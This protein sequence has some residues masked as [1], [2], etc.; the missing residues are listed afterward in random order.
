M[1]VTLRCGY[2][3]TGSSIS[4][5]ALRSRSS[6]KTGRNL[7]L[8]TIKERGRII[9]TSDVQ[10]DPYEARD[11]SSPPSAKPAANEQVG[12][13]RPPCLTEA[14]SLELINA[15]AHP[16]E[17]RRGDTNE[18]TPRTAREVL[19]TAF[20]V[21]PHQMLPAYMVDVSPSPSRWISLEPPASSRN[22]SVTADATGP[23]ECASHNGSYHEAVVRQET[24]WHQSPRERPP[25]VFPGRC[26]TPPP[27][28]LTRR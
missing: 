3:N 15:P 9:V 10:P 11:S 27:S 22:V 28:L 2:G 12:S 25:T 24:G 20:D 18:H 13:Q 26:L 8:N 6:R 5:R 1:R 16:D 19:T 17:L 14:T 4:S 7:P 23:G 21:V